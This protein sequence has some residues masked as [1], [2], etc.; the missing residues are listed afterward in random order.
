MLA[1]RRLTSDLICMRKTSQHCGRRPAHVH[2][3]FLFTD[4]QL[5]PFWLLYVVFSVCYAH[6]KCL[7]Q[8]VL[9]LT[10]IRAVIKFLN[11]RNIKPAEIYGQVTEVYSEYAIS[12]GMVRKWVRMFNAGRTNVHAEAR[13]GRPSVVTDDLERKVDEAIHEN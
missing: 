11:T 12:D 13:S 3:F 7:R 9:P 5:S 4:F 1:Y 6:S 10:E 2:W 8:L